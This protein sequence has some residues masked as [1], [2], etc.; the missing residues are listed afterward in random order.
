MHIKTSRVS[1]YKSK[2][3]F[4]NTFIWKDHSITEG[5][6]WAP[7]Q[8]SSV[9]GNDYTLR[10]VQIHSWQRWVFVTAWWH[11]S[12]SCLTH[13]TRTT[14]ILSYTRRCKQGAWYKLMNIKRACVNIQRQVSIPWF[15]RRLRT[16]ALIVCKRLHCGG[17][18]RPMHSK[19]VRLNT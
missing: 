18:I 3:V 6:V 7:R 10:K 15:T 9:C 5:R 19:R 16:M 12:I 14:V 17:I 11:V 2:L 8:S 4:S 13:N 1:L